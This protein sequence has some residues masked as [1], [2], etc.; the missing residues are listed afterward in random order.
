MRSKPPRWIHNTRRLEGL[1]TKTFQGY[2][3]G[4]LSHWWHLHCCWHWHGMFS[5]DRVSI[6]WKKKNTFFNTRTGIAIMMEFSSQWWGWYNIGIGIVIAIN[7]ILVTMMELVLISIITVT[8]INTVFVTMMGWY[9]L[10]L[11]SLVAVARNRGLGLL[12]QPSNPH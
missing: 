1:R 7:T 5:N 3:T 8:A 9:L 11:A 12:Q 10:A 4:F 6:C 2:L